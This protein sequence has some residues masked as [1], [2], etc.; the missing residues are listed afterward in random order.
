MADG[1]TSEWSPAVKFTTLGEG[2]MVLF[3]DADNQNEIEQNNGNEVNVT[4][5]GRTLCK[6]GNWNT[7]CLPFSMTAAQIAA[8]TDF[9]GATLMTLDLDET[10]R[11]GFDTTDG[12][13]YL[14]FKTAT[15][16][17]A[18]VPYL[19][20]WKKAADYDANPSAYDIVNPVFDGVT[21]HNTPA[22]TVEA[23]TSDLKLVQMIGTYSPFSLTANDKSIL[24]LGKANKLYYPSADFQI[25]SC[26]AFFSV[27]YIKGNPEAQARAFALNFDAE[28]TGIE[29]I[30]TPS[31]PSN[32]YFTLD[33]LRLSRKP[34]Q[35]GLYILNG[36][37]TLIK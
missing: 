3:D 8:N 29:T 34:T 35:R 31:N 36:Q 21:I 2:E 27:P 22:Q 12:T 13:L 6:D 19:V 25:H 10:K 32:L 17:E 33:G 26:R 14:S 4:L 30:S 5:Q 15:E 1:K 16:I 37:K 9:A 24:Y 7:L 28:D 18:G 23:A 20:K 11:N